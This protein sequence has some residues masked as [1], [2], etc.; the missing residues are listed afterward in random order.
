MS[1][2]ART[3]EEIMYRCF[4]FNATSIYRACT[5]EIMIKSVVPE[6]RKL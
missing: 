5:V 3:A 2:K 6:I 1:S 4:V